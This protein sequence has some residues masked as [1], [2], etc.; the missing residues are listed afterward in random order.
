[1]LIIAC[2][3]WGGATVLNKTLLTSAPPLVL[4]TLQLAASVVGLWVVVAVKRAPLPSGRHLIALFALGLLNPGLAYSLSL[5]GLARV[6]ASMTTLL[7][8]SEPLLIVPLAALLLREAVTWRFV[9]VL[10][11]GFLGVTLVVG[12]IGGLTNGDSDAGGVILLLLGVLCCALYTV[13]SRALVGVADSLPIVAIQQ[14]AGALYAAAVLALGTRFGS[15]HELVALPPA[16]VATAVISGL[17]Y[18]AAAYWLY[19]TA[20]RFVPAGVAGAYF[21]A[22]PVFG[23]GLAVIFLGETL[24]LSQWLGALLIGLSVI[25]LVRLTPEHPGPKAT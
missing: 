2:A 13:L 6:S 14:S 11:L 25:G 19:L 21:N 4:L 7:W 18:Y 17:L 22:I 3:F 23:V 1:M 24:T 16:T 10:A 9:A 20:L 12:L 15:I 8:A 5:M